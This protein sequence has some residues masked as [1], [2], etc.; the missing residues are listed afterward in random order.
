MIFKALALSL[1]FA[2]CSAANV[3]AQTH[4]CDAP[5]VTV[6]KTNAPIG[7]GFCIKPIDADGIPVPLTSIASFRVK[8][9]EA[10]VFNG[11]LTPIGTPSATG[12][13]YYETPNNLSVAKGQHVVLVYVTTAN[14][15]ESEGSDPFT[16]TLS[17]VGLGKPIV[18][19]PKK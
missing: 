14:G 7:I 15:V 19:G 9:D 3:E 2:T 11:P 12:F 4:P 8:I 10:Q 5:A 16:F 1:F 17:G 18:K 6:I 13:I